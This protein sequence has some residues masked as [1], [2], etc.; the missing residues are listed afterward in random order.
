MIVFGCCIFGTVL[1][2]LWWLPK[3]KAG[4]FIDV[5]WTGDVRDG[6]NNSRGALLCQT[7]DTYANYTHGFAD[8]NAQTIKDNVK[9]NFLTAIYLHA[10]E[11]DLIL[12]QRKLI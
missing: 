3:K 4:V 11:T 8:I 12:S 10:K 7:D 1:T 6:P 9:M 5:P 2:R